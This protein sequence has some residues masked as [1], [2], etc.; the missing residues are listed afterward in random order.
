MMKVCVFVLLF[1]AAAQAVD[2]RSTRATEVTPPHKMPVAAVPPPLPATELPK[3]APEANS[4]VGCEVCKQIIKN[5][6]RWTNR[7]EDLC[8]GVPPED[9][10]LQL[11][12]REM[13][14][15]MEE[16]S[17][18]QQNECAIEEDGKMVNKAPCPG[19]L[20]CWACAG[21]HSDKCFYE[22]SV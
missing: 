1:A 4:K 21:V 15:K 11:L 14:T 16:C 17:Y 8:S 10:D 7:P 18:F 9:A 19:N 12:C 6:T 22:P 2:L 13:V 5:R 3:P 20:I